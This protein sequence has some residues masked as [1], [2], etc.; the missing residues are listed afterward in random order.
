MTFLIGSLALA[1]VPP[2]SG[3]FSKDEIILAAKD[4]HTYWLAAVL[5]IGA[6][7]TAF[8]TTRMLLKT[9]FGEYRGKEHLHESPR[10]HDHAAHR[11]RDRH[12]GSSDCLGFAP[13]GA[14]FFDWVYFG[15]PEAAV[16]SPARGRYRRGGAS[17]IASGW[18]MYRDYRA[19]ATRR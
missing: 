12:R 14:P 6:V 5:V 17:A 7:I 3:F 19:S 8:Y 10:T 11:A 15:A 9:F 16:F 2:F 4:R 1:G 13:A 18:V